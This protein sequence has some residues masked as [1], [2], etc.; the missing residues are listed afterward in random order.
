MPGMAL[1]MSFTAFTGAVT[2]PQE[3]EVVNTESNAA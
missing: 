1:L 2:S 3:D